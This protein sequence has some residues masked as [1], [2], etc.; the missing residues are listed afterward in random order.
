[1]EIETLWSM[2]VHDLLSVA[3]E[4]QSYFVSWLFVL[5]EAGLIIL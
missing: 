4:M 2:S 3:V 5:P 1:M